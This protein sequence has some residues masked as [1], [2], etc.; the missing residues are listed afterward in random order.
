MVLPFEGFVPSENAISPEGFPSPP[1]ED[2]LNIE[3]FPSPPSED[4]QDSI[5]YF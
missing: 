4:I 2:A 5:A 3:G 1:S